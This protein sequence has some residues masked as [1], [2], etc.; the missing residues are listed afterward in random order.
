MDNAHGKEKTRPPLDNVFKGLQE[1]GI[2]TFGA[3]GYCLGGRY[4]FDLAFEHIIKV[5]VTAHPSRLQIPADLEKY[6]TTCTAPLLINSCEVDKQFPIEA[7]A[8]ADEILG[9]GKFQPGYL[10]TNADGCVHGFAVRGDLSNP[11]VTAGKE[12]AFK[13][14]VEWFQKHL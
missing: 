3:S 9:D 1:R 10:R 12:L 5:S 6:A 11:K 7:Q 14:S 13:A 4:V 8:K 2:T